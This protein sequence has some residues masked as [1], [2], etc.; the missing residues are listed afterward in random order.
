MVSRD[1]YDCDDALFNSKE[2]IGRLGLR[3]T[4]K[5]TQYNN[6]GLFDALKPFL[7]AGNNIVIRSNWTDFTVYFEPFTLKDFTCTAFSKK[8]KQFIAKII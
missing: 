8:L 2:Q 3:T 7:P 1:S 4:A 6:R 5:D